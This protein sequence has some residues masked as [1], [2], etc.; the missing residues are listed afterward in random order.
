M[1]DGCI[2]QGQ[3]ALD[4]RCR[5]G[6]IEQTKETE[7]MEE[8]EMRL[9]LRIEYKRL[10]EEKKKT[11]QGDSPSYIYSSCNSHTSSYSYPR[12]SHAYLYSHMCS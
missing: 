2:G 12:N 1:S 4:K 10:H 8:M 11:K 6:G 7:E 9:I 3:A 5:D